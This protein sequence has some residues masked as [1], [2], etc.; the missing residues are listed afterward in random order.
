MSHQA[1]I[2]FDQSLEPYVE[3]VLSKKAASP[4][5]LD[6]RGKSAVT[7]AILVCSGKSSRQVAALA[8]AVRR[9][10]R[11]NY[12]IKPLGIEGEQEGHWV[13]MD[14]GDVLIHIFYESIREFYD[15]EGL[16]TDARNIVTPQLKAYEEERLEDSHETA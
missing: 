3:A 8:E 2:V 10:L 1:N 4:V 11:K 5:L 12:K 7:D 13:L 16:W 6:V 15:I 9:Y 14:Y